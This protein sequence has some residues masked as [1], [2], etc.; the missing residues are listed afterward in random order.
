MSSILTIPTMDT[1]LIGDL[2]EAKFLALCIEYGIAISKP[3]GDNIRYDFIIDINGV[4]LRIQCKHG[5][6]K[7][8]CILANTCSHS[9]YS[10]IPRRSYVGDADYFA[11][12]SEYTDKFYLVKIDNSTPIGNLSLRLSPTKNGQ[13]KGISFAKDFEF[14]R[15]INFIKNNYTYVD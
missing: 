12:Y 10:N 9:P 6:V 8:N 1:K 4:L 3:F 7:G 2:V 11:V 15:V 5:R 13:N 14:D